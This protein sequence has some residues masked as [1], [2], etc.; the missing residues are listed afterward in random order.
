MPNRATG[1]GDAGG[2]RRPRPMG[3]WRAAQR[4]ALLAEIEERR[5][6]FGDAVRRARVVKPELDPA[7]TALVKDVL[8]DGDTQGEFGALVAATAQP[9]CDRQRI[10][11]RATDLARLR[12]YVLPVEDLAI[13]GRDAYAELG[14]WQVPAVVLANLQQTLTRD[15]SGTYSADAQVREE[16]MR[17][18]RA[19]LLK[20][21]ET[22]D[23]WDRYTDWFFATLRYAL[24]VLL[25]VFVLSLAGAVGLLFT[26][27]VASGFILAGL[28]GAAVSIMLK[29]PPLSV[30]GEFASFAVKMVGR[31]A[32]GMAAA[33]I[34]LGALAVGLV[35]IPLIENGTA[36]S[37]S[38]L[39]NACARADGEAKAP[40]TAASAERG[41]GPALVPSQGGTA[42]AATTAPGC[43]T[44]WRLVLLALGMLLGFSERALASFEDAAF[45]TQSARR[46][47]PA[48]GPP[49]VAPGGPPPAAA[50]APAGG[51]GPR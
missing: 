9:D 34:G 13:E 15:L 17:R 14:E 4:S 25:G 50:G 32:A 18:A 37:L 5:G 40:A 12:V 35:N 2:E 8:G 16:E 28:S 30:F 51:P 1:Q 27:H 41:A 42:P 33:A 21:L 11:R 31:G 10:A 20:I 29:L 38:V 49:V 39:I 48:A 46:P 7:V 26:G 3:P 23:Y 24:G 43:S 22:Y 44:V 45:G 19:G 6:V 47:A 36:V